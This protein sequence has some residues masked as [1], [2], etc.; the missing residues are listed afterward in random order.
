[1]QNV[2]VSLT[3]NT[4]EMQH[5]AILLLAKVPSVCGAHG[6]L[7]LAFSQDIGNNPGRSS[8]LPFRVEAILS[9]KVVPASVS[10]PEP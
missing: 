4:E 8:H 9:P 5:W 3:S 2:L 1:M 7:G 10:L 6:I